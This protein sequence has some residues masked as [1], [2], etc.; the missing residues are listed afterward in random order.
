MDTVQYYST[1]ELELETV[2]VK[3][4]ARFS[5]ISIKIPHRILTTFSLSDL[6]NGGPVPKYIGGIFQ[7]SSEPQRAASADIF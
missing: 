6:S 7:T 2:Y 3:G 1:M 5:L 4:H